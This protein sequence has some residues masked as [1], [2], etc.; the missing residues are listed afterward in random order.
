MC[1]EQAGEG[2]GLT[3]ETVLIPQI[4]EQGHKRRTTLCV[5]SQVSCTM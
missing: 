1:A 5:S 3:V 2:R 4:R